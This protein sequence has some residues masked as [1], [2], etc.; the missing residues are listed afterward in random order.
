MF[1]SS[2][3]WW[4]QG[5]ALCS[6]HWAMPW[7]TNV[8]LSNHVCWNR[9]KSTIRWIE[10]K[11]NSTQYAAIFSIW[12]PQH[13]H[14]C[15]LSLNQGCNSSYS[16]EVPM[17][18]IVDTVLQNRLEDFSRYTS[19]AIPWPSIC[20]ITLMPHN[21]YVVPARFLYFGTDSTFYTSKPPQNEMISQCHFMVPWP[22]L[23]M[24]EMLRKLT[25][26][27]SVQYRLM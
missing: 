22:L 21:G 10:A 20:Q 8:R 2:M 12:S 13:P 24:E 4:L 14:H 7:S 27:S 1:L 11:L 25:R 5:Y 6:Y 19:L 15:R 3:P 9:R 17:V 26:W 16:A 18:M 23:G